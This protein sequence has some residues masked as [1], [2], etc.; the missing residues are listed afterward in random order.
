[1]QEPSI[2]EL[3]HAVIN[4][5]DGDVFAISDL[6]DACSAFSAG[7]LP[8][9]KAAGLSVALASY[10]NRRVR[11]GSFVDAELLARTL[12]AIRH[13]A[14]RD[15]EE[16]VL[17]DSP[18]GDYTELCSLLSEDAATAG[19]TGEN[20]PNPIELA[21][22]PPPPGKEVL[23]QVAGDFFGI[24]LAEASERLILAQEE[25]MRLED[26]PDTADAC[27]NL[28][29]TF[30]TLK[31]ESGFFKLDRMSAFA[32]SY[33]NLLD[34]MRQGA[35]KVSGDLVDL[36]LRGV[37][38]FQ[39]MLALLQTDGKNSL[40]SVPLDDLLSSIEKLRKG[41]V[42]E[43][44]PEHLAK[45]N[46]TSLSEGQASQSPDTGDADQSQSHLVKA[47]TTTDQFIKVQ[48]SQINYL[49]DMI[50]ELVI[51]QN[52]LSA[53]DQ[54]AVALRKVTKEIQ[55][56]ALKLRTTRIKPVAVNMQRA[57]R[58]V[59]RSLGKELTFE[60]IGDDIEI[61]RNLVEGLSEPL[62]HMI[63][64]SA[65]HGIEKAE[66]RIAMGKSAQGKVRLV[67]ERKGNSIVIA[68]EDDGKGL[69]RSAILAKA[70][71][72]GLVKEESVPG[73]SD[74]EVWDF[75]FHPG[76]STAGE[77][78]MISGRGVGMDIVKNFVTNNR[79]R[80]EV[81]TEPDRY[82]KISLHFPVNTAIVDGMIVNVGDLTL[83]VPVGS[84]VESL[85]LVESVYFPVSGRVRVIN[86][87]GEIL[88]VIDLGEYFDCVVP[89]SGSRIGIVVEDSLQRRFVFV[90]EAIVG[91]REVVIK[92]LGSRF[93]DLKSI[94]SGT[95][96][97]GGKVAYLVD[98]E[99]IV[100][101]FEG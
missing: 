8:N 22:E 91:K 49:V 35:L 7:L 57:L 62:A 90:V 82:T 93:K 26:G 96:L 19:D 61:D 38:R 47:R 56:A 10:L 81:Q 101:D 98:V 15:S 67:A 9:G 84:I 76:F 99:H 2:D 34:T 71:E 80:V 20:I 5:K 40:E 88:P 30:H 17:P 94:N 41:E 89:P 69:D 78:G 92:T 50:G 58:D 33:E 14:L 79:G 45:E 72:R 74:R 12:D 60:S 18:D 86:L 63:R 44:R 36:L 43:S 51:A 11:D 27:Q 3:S 53:N 46:N 55:N 66:R 97:S 64:N 87:R 59:S 4:L 83:I 75:I 31:G 16:L 100:S 13:Y 42:A 77:I 70:I 1:M 25:C 48:A 73:L 29:R 85:N 23:T 95:V 52:Q 37:D 28:F 6:A 68:V 39:S 32:H 21:G 54:A 24:F 65:H